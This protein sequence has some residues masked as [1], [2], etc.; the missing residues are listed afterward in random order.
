MNDEK[1]RVVLGKAVGDSF[2]WAVDSV[3]GNVLIGASGD[4]ADNSGVAYLL[5]VKD[6]PLGVTSIVDLKP[7]IFV[8]E[9][10]KGSFLVAL[11][12]LSVIIWVV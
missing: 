1:I 4:G 8:S 10:E 7:T 5:R 9:G 11:L 2:G 3:G 12:L 6:I